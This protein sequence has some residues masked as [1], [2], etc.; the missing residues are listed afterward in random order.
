MLLAAVVPP[1]VAAFLVLAAP[2]TMNAVPSPITTYLTWG[3]GLAAYLIGVG[4]MVRLYPRE[5]EEH[6]RS[7]RFERF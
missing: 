2:N 4:S 7:W 1:L 5:A 3:T 6:A